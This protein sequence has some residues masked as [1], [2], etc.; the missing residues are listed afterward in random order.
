MNALSGLM[1]PQ[2]VGQG[3]QSAFQQ[4]QQMRGDM[5]T[6][7]A[8]AT[9]AGNPEDADA[10]RNLTFYNPQVGM[11]MQDRQRQQQAAE[12]QA[13]ENQRKAR[14]EQMGTMRQLLQ[15]AGSNPQQAFAAAQQL[16]ID[17]SQIPQPGSPDFEPWRQQQLFIMDAL[18]KEGDNLPG[19]AREVMLALPEDQRDANSPAFRQA[20]TAALENKYA[21]EYTDAQGNT[22]RR[23]IIGG[24]QGAS[25]QVGGTS[26]EI[27]TFE[28]LQG[29]AQSLPPEAMQRQIQRL[30]QGGVVFAVNTPEQARQLPSGASIRLPDGSIGRV[31]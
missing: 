1:N 31:P 7:N 18:E 23:A 27:M 11:Q 29:I 30:M 22:R 20:F 15:Q 5:E 3:V 13:A 26:G 2:A 21:A 24:Q 19:L 6:R 16:G 10:M 8:L 14:A 28:Q 12:A 17:V 4:G 25:P 9:L